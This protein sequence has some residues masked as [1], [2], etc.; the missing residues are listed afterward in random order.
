MANNPI[1]MNKLRQILK[2]HCQGQSKLFISEVTGMSRNTVKKYL[3]QF[4]NLK[5]T[6]EEVSSLN[7]HELNKLFNKEPELV[8]PEQLLALYK[9][10]PEAS[11][12]LKLPGMTQLKLW[13]EYRC[14]NPDGYKKSC[15][16][17]HFNLWRRRVDPSLPI[18]HKAGDKIYIDFAGEK[19]SIIDKETG[20]LKTVEVFVAILGGTQYTY[21]EAVENQ[22]TEELIFA[23]ENALHFFG[24]APLAIV[25][26]NLKSA[27]IKSSKYEPKINENFA[28]FAGH[29]GMAVIPTRAY[30]PKDK[31]LVEGAVK[32]AYNR[33]YTNLPA[34][35][36]ESIEELNKAIMKLLIEHNNTPLTGRTYSRKEHFEEIEKPVLQPLP[37]KRYEL[38]TYLQLTVMKNGHV[39]INCDRHYYSVPYGYI[40][41]KV[42]VLF[43]KSLVEIYYKYELIASHQRQKSPYNYTTDPA[44]LATHHKI[45]GEWSPEYFLNRARNIHPDVEFFISQVLLKKPH[46]EQAYRSCNG[47][48]SFAK[49]VGDARLVK[50]CQRAHSYGLYH[51]GIIESILQKRLD[52]QDEF[53]IPETMPVHENIRGGNYY[54]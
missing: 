50:A 24:G 21:V 13:E 29:Y 6:Y 2:L 40:G 20:E 23:C 39:F 42:R 11:K 38:R 7:D 53:T 30:R 44:H 25:P 4:I 46:P 14:K 31:A 17:R 37:E 51:Y 3:K 10:F 8:P 36:F 19:L 1:N 48:L 16:N 28:G 22:S 15:F 34:E 54:L 49:R 43:S 45:I 27:V 9:F 18:H 52:E 33:I 35:P 12:R 47:I 32:I 5:M 41:K 26:D